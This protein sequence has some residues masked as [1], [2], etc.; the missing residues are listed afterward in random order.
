MKR[1][2]RHIHF[3]SIGVLLAS[4]LLSFGALGR[5]TVTADSHLTFLRPETGITERV[6]VAKDDGG[7]IG[8]LLSHADVQLS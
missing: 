4:S 2:T 3:L 7:Q 5:S 8:R 1:H 6:E